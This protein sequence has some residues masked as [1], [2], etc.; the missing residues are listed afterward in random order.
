[1]QDNFLKVKSAYD[2]MLELNVN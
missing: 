2:R 1:M